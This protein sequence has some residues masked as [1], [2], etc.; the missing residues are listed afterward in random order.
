MSVHGVVR[1]IVANHPGHWGDW[2]GSAPSYRSATGSK[3][4]LPLAIGE[5]KTG[6]LA[7]FVVEF[8]RQLRMPA[9]T[10]VRVA[11]QGWD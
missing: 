6:R 9:R 4:R 11:L 7:G 2:R 5:R 3:S 1:L 10:D 8:A